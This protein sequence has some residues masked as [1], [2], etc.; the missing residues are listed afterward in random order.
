MVLPL[1]FQVKLNFPS[2]MGPIHL[3]FHVLLLRKYVDD[4]LLVVPLEEPGILECLFL[5]ENLSDNHG[6]VCST[7]ENKSSGFSDGPM[8]EPIVQVIYLGG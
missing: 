8:E 2:S 1:S 6:L 5:C 4:P 7:V 3:V